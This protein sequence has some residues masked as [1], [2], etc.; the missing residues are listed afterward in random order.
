MS[1]QTLSPTIS[2][3]HMRLAMLT[4]A[5]AI[6][7]ANLDISIV[8]IALPT[9]SAY[10]QADA[11]EVA[12]IILSYMLA[13]TSLLL[14]AGKLSDLYS[15]ERVLV[16]GYWV[17]IIGSALCGLA[18]SLGWLTAFRFLQGIGGALLF[19]TSA[20]I[21]VHY[22]PVERRGRAYALNG[23]LAVTALAF[24]APVGGFLVEYVGWHWIFLINVPIGLAALTL[25]HLAFVRQVPPVT[26]ISFDLPGAAYSFLCLLGFIYGM[27][28]GQDQ[29]WTQ[30]VTLLS[31][32]MCLGFLILFLHRERHCPEPLL[33]LSLFSNRPLSAAMLGNSLFLALSGGLSF[34]LPFYLQWIKHLTPD[35]VGLILMISPALSML[36]TTFSGYLSDRI[37]PRTVCIAAMVGLF[38][39]AVSFTTLGA[40]SSFTWIIA[41]Q[42]LYGVSRAFYI[43]AALT[44][45]MSYAQAGQAGMLSGAKALLLNLGLLIGVSLFAL[46]YNLPLNDLPT[47]IDVPLP[48]VVQGFHYA[49]GLGV[50]IAALGL[51]ATIISRPFVPLSASPATSNI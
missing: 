16:W 11:A 21:I 36:L 12:T 42:A 38:A 4:S 49:T 7:M 40:D 31:L 41:C 28:V 44:M 10:Y 33:A 47:P 2:P 25:A 51:I 30:P 22:V 45:I 1:D 14:V 43:T 26:K 24:G 34:V 9:L 15:A 6:F 20:V 13:I 37:G 19:A 3:G 8:N 29:G 46:L 35:Q 48:L 18:P 5:L 32:A 39:T 17:F 50:V 27:H 23:L